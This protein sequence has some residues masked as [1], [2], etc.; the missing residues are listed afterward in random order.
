MKYSIVEILKAIA[1]DFDFFFSLYCKQVLDIKRTKIKI[2][3]QNNY[4]QQQ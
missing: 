2:I 3:I 1:G 4:Y